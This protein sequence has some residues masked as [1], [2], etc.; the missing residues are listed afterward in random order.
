MSDPAARRPIKTRNTSFAQGSATFLLK[1]GISPN[2]ISVWSVIF[3]GLG[4]GCLLLGGTQR[5]V[6]S[7]YWW[8]GAI[9]F[10][11]CRLLC[12]LFD[13]MVA[14]EGGKATPNGDLYNEVPD[15]LSDIL[16]FVAAG[17]ACIDQPWGSGLGWFVAVASLLTAYIRLHGASLLKKHDF[18]GPMA[19]AHRMFSLCVLCGIL[20]FSSGL[21][22][23]LLT[24][25]LGF[26]GLGAMLTFMLRVFRLS[27]E[28][29]KSC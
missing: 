8:Y 9:L 11:Q 28:L 15:R 10:I 25:G 19:K 3:A 27:K 23:D 20:P 24:Y 2:L 12:N 22:F 5:E 26:I 17:Y 16:L 4:A 13:G 14:V 7:W 6:D 29:Y 21:P 1:L 18:G